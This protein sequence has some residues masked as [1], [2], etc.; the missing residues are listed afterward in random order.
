MT[1]DPVCGMEVDKENAVTA[2]R[3]G[4]TYYFCCEHCRRSFLESRGEA[5]ADEDPQPEGQAESRA[6]TG[7]Y[8]CPMCD[9][10]ASD[11]RGAC[12]K[13]GMALERNTASV[14]EE[15][16]DDNEVRDMTRR[17]WGS[18]AFGVPVFVIAMSGMVGIR[19]LSY[20]VTKWIELALATPV[21]LWGGSI[22]FRRGWQSIVNRSLNMFSL[23]ALGTGTA[24][25]YSVVAVIVP[26]IF[27]P[28]FRTD[29]HVAIYFEAAA[30][31][32]VLV[33]V[34]QVL[35]L[36][37]R[38]RT[39]SAVREL[40]ELAPARARV[41]RDGEEQDVPVEEV[42]IDDRLRVRPGEKIPVDGTVVDGDS[43][44]DE[45]MI[46][47]EP[48]PVDKGEGDTVTGGTLNTSGTFEMKAEKVGSDTVLSQIVDMVTAAQRSRAPIQR[49][50]DVVAAYFVPAV[51][52]VA[53]IAFVVWALVGPEPRMAYALV[54]AVSVLIVA[55]P[56]ALGL[57]TPMSIM[58]G[59]GRGAS[60]GVL[61]K[62]AEN[63]EAMEKVDTLIVDKTG[64]LT[65]GKPRVARI[66]TADD[67]A[68]EQVL[69]LAASV[70]HYSEHPLAAAVAAAAEERGVAL[71]DAEQFASE[72][73]GGVSAAVDGK[74]VLVGQESFLREAN[75]GGMEGLRD[76]VDKWQEEGRTVIWVAAEGGARG[77][78]ALED[79]V[80][81]TT[82]EAVEQLH[83]CGLDIVMVTGD[84]ERTA[85]TVADELGIDRVVAGVAPQDKHKEVEKL[86]QQ[87]HRV[88]VA[89][90][91]IND[92]PALAAA[93]VGIAMG[94]GTDVAIES[95]GIT[96]VRGDLRGIGRAVMLS[97]Q[98]MRNIRQNL[99]FAFV[100]N[101][102]GIPIAAGVL[103]PFF[104]ILLSP[105]IAAAA[106]SLS[107]VSVV[108]NALRLRKTTL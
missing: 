6:G 45:S 49:V 43:S 104:G 80:K 16:D 9:G 94:S 42:R 56:C 29:G 72:T 99:F 90:D 19:F 31:I 12:P 39:S 2:D 23:I 75:T 69:H 7:A 11:T 82:P 64:T 88:A 54:T 57:A 44:V 78:L 24:Y 1:K 51:L 106:M 79:P 105:M 73:G 3:D 10:V 60:D 27:P 21:V 46:T 65:E 5:A 76:T 14:G 30:M 98:V 32:T 25:V 107:S 15:D 103:Y 41:V 18:L 97:R 47:G 71:S 55:C 13:C 22:F 101:S 52:G 33:L 102:V 36:R 35:E 48:L 89:G 95:A 96:L 63:L 86:Q 68:E 92:A 61:I 93:D 108:S 37:A 40:L 62:E 53:V 50:A 8:I 28:S 84:N 83:R 81:K 87:G 77:V 20:A 17:L 66:Q 85:R 100:Y 34:G 4:T 26:G 91:G 70:E 58:V 67:F 74:P 38:R 59:V